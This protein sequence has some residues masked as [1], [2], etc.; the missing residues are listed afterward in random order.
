LIIVFLY[1]LF[2][3]KY[4]NKIWFIIVSY[5][6]TA[7][8]TIILFAY[9]Y[10][11]L[12]IFGLGYLQFNECIIIDPQLK[13]EN[14][15]YFSSVTFYALGYGD[16]CPILPFTRFISQIEV[17]LGVII[18]TILIGFIFWKI[19]ERDIEEEIERRK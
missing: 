15:F 9:I 11:T 14:W 3:I 10:W 8:V 7:I 12:S 19:R 6:F 13:S 2:A 17:V 16:I 5:V 1:S 4:S 18:N